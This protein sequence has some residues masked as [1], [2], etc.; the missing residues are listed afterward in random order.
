MW[1]EIAPAGINIQQNRAWGTRQG[2][3]AI[4]GAN[5]AHRFEICATSGGLKFEA[6]ATNRFLRQEPKELHHFHRGGKDVRTLTSGDLTSLTMEF[7]RTPDPSAA[8]AA[9]PRTAEGA[10][11]ATT[12]PTGGPDRR[13]IKSSFQTLFTPTVAVTPQLFA[14]PGAS[15]LTPFINGVVT[16]NF[17]TPAIGMMPGAPATD[18]MSSPYLQAAAKEAVRREFMNMPSYIAAPPPGASPAGFV[19]AS[20][21]QGI[22]LAPAPQLVRPADGALVGPDAA[23]AR[24]PDGPSPRPSTTAKDGSPGNQRVPQPGAQ[25]VTS[26]AAAPVKPAAS[27]AAAVRPGPPFAGGPGGA[28]FPMHGAPAGMMVMGPGGP[29]MMQGAPMLMHPGSGMMMMAQRAPGQPP[30]MMPHPGMM[31]VAPAHM[32]AAA[33]A[34]VAAAKPETATERK[35]RVEREK[36]ELIREF[37]KKTREAALVR[38]RQ[39]RR[40]RRFGKLI[41]YD[42]RKKLADARPRV[43]GRFVRI[44]AEDTDADNEE[45]AQVV[46]SME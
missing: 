42:C 11:S 34:R 39:K 29:I 32:Q 36:Q 24:V 28:M 23:E 27:A 6:L 16:P 10:A 8:W 45:G 46:P 3:F 7:L 35:D 43:K 4:A 2:T 33:A 14:K 21:A 31:M 13:T 20:A 44:K 19:P 26:S 18:Y 40:E 15:G 41:R 38:F 17:V 12:P 30:M 37:K 5:G 9:T 22:A 25:A 1:R